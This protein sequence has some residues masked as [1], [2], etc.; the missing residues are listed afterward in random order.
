MPEG[1]P[2]GTTVR[3]ISGRFVKRIGVIDSSIYGESVDFPG[4]AAMGYGVVLDNDE[5]I[6]V[7]QDQV[8]TRFRKSLDRREE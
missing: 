4:A 2:R 5:W 3:I 8:R 7:R 1:L 6:V